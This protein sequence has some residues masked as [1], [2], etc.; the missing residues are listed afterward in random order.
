M[1]PKFITSWF[2]QPT[3]SGSMGTLYIFKAPLLGYERSIPSVIKGDREWIE[4]FIPITEFETLFGG[5]VTW[6][7]TDEINETIGVWD[8]RNVSRFRR[9]LR[10]RGAQFDVVEG[11][12]PKQDPWVVT[13]FGYTKKGKRALR[14]RK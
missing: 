9:F 11:E 14:A 3:K 8:N 12:G 13:T 10:E 4:Q 1:I 5:Y 7:P 6:R 2:R